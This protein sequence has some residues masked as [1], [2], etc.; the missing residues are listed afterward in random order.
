MLTI[1]CGPSKEEQYNTLKQETLKMAQEIPELF[2][3]P[4][5]IKTKMNFDRSVTPHEATET[6]VKNFKE[7]NN[8]AIEKMPAI[9]KNVAK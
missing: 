9:E 1:G 8:K 2:K 4:K 3:K 7:A 5:E 6:N